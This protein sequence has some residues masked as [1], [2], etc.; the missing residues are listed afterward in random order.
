MC[1]LQNGHFQPEAIYGDGKSG[2][3]IAD[4]LTRAPLSVEKKLEY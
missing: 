1:H 2:A 4:L 3:R